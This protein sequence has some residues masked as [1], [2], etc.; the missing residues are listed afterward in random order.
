MTAA[1]DSIR[2]G[3]PTGTTGN[4]SASSELLVV[5][6]VDVGAES[7]KVVLGQDYSCEIVRNDVGGHTTPTMIALGE[8]DKQPR[9]LGTKVSKNGVYHLNRLLDGEIVSDDDDDNNNN[10]NND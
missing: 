10:N 3:T 8:T 2:T 9:Q 5:V 7:T 6:G 4:N 1:E